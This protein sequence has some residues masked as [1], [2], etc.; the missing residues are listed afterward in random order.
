MMVGEQPGDRED[1]EGHPFVGPA[2]GILDKALVDL[3]IAREKVY[4]TNAVKHFKWAPKGK[5]RIHQTPRASELRACRPWLEAEIEAVSPRIIACLGATAVRSLL[6]PSV[7][8]MADRGRIIESVYGVCL[9]T[10][11]PSSL[12]RVETPEERR[13]AYKSFLEDLRRGLAFLGS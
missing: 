11:H 5:R 4:I 6:G 10:V 12:L 13:A 1:I 9:V 2:G 7:K 8:V 3:G